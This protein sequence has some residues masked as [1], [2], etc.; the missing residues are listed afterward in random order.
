MAIVA[1]AATMQAPT[2][3]P[4]WR[5]LMQAFVGHQPPP[6]AQVED[7]GDVAMDEEE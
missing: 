7:Q 2:D 4:V 6:P 1:A 3:A 5:Q